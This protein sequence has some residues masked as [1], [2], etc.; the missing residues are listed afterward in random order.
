MQTSTSKSVVVGIV[1][2]I[3]LEALGA[4]LWDIAVKPGGS[5]FWHAILTYATFGSKVLKDNVYLEAAKGNHEAVSLLSVLILSGFVGMASGGVSSVFLSPRMR[6]NRTHSTSPD[7]SIEKT[8]WI[9]PFAPVI[10]RF[11]P[12]AVAALGLLIL[13]SYV[14]MTL[15]VATANDLYTNFEQSLDICRPYLTEHQAQVLK[16]R[17]A[18]LRTREEYVAITNEMGQ[19]ADSNHL[20]L[21]DFKPW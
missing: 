8:L 5:W 21:P 11:V 19:V 18:A 1:V 4:G 2:T 16:S 10:R 9:E 13:G 12:V 7:G 15:R 6:R 3:V 17:Y 20:R 14:V